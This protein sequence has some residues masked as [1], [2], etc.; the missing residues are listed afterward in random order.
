MYS[1]DIDVKT[2]FKTFL[3]LQNKVTAY[4]Y[5]N[6]FNKKI[7]T[8]FLLVI[9]CFALFYVIVV[10]CVYFVSHFNNL[11]KE[12]NLLIDKSA[13]LFYKFPVSL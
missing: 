10:W 5:K 8:T 1:F 3:S 4:A 12:I 13:I 7:H 6:I 9:T 11:S 2:V